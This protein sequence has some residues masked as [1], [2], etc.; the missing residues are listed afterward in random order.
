MRLI[1]SQLFT[2]FLFL[3]TLTAAI[4]IVSSAVVSKTMR[5]RITRRWAH[6]NL[7][8]VQKLCGVAY[9]VEGQ[10]HLVQRDAVYYWKHQST[11]ETIALFTLTPTAVVVLKNELMRLPMVGWCF[12]VMGFVAIDRN[13]GHSAVNQ[14]VRKG[15]A[16]LD[17]GRTVVIFPEGTR[18]APGRTRRYGVSGALLA[19]RSGRPIIPIAHNAGDFWPRRGLR[20]VPGTIRV[21]IGPPIET[22]GKKPADINREASDWI[23]ETMRKISPAYRNTETE[24]E[25]QVQPED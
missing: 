19:E 13:S 9:T 15:T 23:E 20:K 6:A 5:F 4:C 14:V 22:G 7:W 12:I 8:L 10:E 18:M 25:V 24:G 16:S 21:V 3:S 2:L 1:R 17:S 11:F